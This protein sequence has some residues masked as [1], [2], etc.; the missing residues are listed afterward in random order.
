MVA[1]R[2]RAAPSICV[3]LSV[4]QLAYLIV[5]C[6]GFATL[7]RLTWPAST[8][9]SVRRGIAGEVGDLID[10]APNVPGLASSS[11]GDAGRHRVNASSSVARADARPPHRSARVGLLMLIVDR[12]PAWWPYL[13]ATYKRN[14][15]QYTLL[16]MHTADTYAAPPG[17][18]VDDGHIQYL[19]ISPDELR[20]RFVTRLGASEAQATSKLA[21]LKGLSD[22]KP[23]YGKLFEGEIGEFTHWGWVDWDILLGDMAAIIPERSLWETDA[24]TFP[25]ATLGFAWAGQLTIFQNRPETRE[26][27]RVADDFLALGFRSS[28][29]ASRSAARHVGK[30]TSPTATSCRLHES[31]IELKPTLI[32]DWS[33]R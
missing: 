25:G 20:R 15:P 30:P 28:G 12:F 16:A 26:L 1:S 14:A 8:V 6:V 29:A 7:L 19:H 21:T 11:V 33:R 23:F 27:Y 22:L 13:V 5:S 9:V 31:P 17:T 24:V 18:A 2:G 4:R 32:L 3:A 10:G